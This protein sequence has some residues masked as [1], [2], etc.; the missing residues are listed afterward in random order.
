MSTKYY[1]V[2][3]QDQFVLY[4]GTLEDC[5]TLLDQSYGG[6]SILTF[7]Q[8]DAKMKASLSN[9]HKKKGKTVQ[10]KDKSSLYSKEQ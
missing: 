1:V 3:L 7:S 5:S 6:L 4:S 8:L 10:T 9:L 2:D